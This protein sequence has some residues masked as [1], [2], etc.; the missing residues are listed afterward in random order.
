MELPQYQM[1]PHTWIVC[2]GDPKYRLEIRETVP[3]AAAAEKYGRITIEAN[4][5][6]CEAG[7]REL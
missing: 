2:G 4:S 5:E 6:A 3:N 7:H 1:Y